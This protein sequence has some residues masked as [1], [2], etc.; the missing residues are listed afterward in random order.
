MFR[1]NLCYLCGGK[2]VNGKCVEC[3]LDNARSCNKTY[4]LNEST[5][6]EHMDEITGE[7]IQTGEE[8]KRQKFLKK[9][10]KSE[11][12]LAKKLTKRGAAGKSSNSEMKGRFRISGLVL[13]IVFA[14]FGVVR[15]AWDEYDMSYRIEQIVGRWGNEEYTEVE[16]DPYEYAKRELSAEG[17]VFE[18]DLEPGNY[19]VGVHIPEGNY[20]MVLLEGY[21][22]VHIEDAENSIYM[23][24]DFGD[25][26][27]FDEVQEA[28][29]IRLYVGALLKVQGDMRLQLETDCAQAEK[30]T[31]MENPLTDTIL[32][33][34]GKE[35]IVGEDFPAGVYDVQ[36]V[37][38]WTGVDVQVPLG[39]DYED[40]TMNYFY[41]GFW[42]SS[43][44]FDHIYRNM[45][46][47]EGTRVIPEDADIE[48][49]PSEKIES[50]DYEAYYEV[51]R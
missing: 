32:L 43:E 37:S 45:V 42:L 50:E 9:Q 24:K 7:C 17:E 8:K 12:K 5:I 10:Q 6:E 21:G 27:E 47:M 1:K 19:K 14:F 31:S 4:R 3:G 11:R 40:E 41:E 15:E 23:W 36:S 51:Y 22:S 29:D 49:I 39:T 38:G 26:E 16:E 48:L 2:L 34:E 44:G 35:V 33:K 28:E 30:M 25:D 13:M 20:R 18:T 46:L